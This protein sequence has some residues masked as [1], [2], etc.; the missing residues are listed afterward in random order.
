MKLVEKIEQ[1]LELP[2]EVKEETKDKALR[3]LILGHVN[4]KN[5]DKTYYCPMLEKV[6]RK[7]TTFKKEYGKFGEYII[8]EP[9]VNHLFL[10]NVYLEKEIEILDNTIE[11]LLY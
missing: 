2:K 11:K 7:K 3:E 5:V 6:L 10:G 8:L 4:T 9:G 1:V